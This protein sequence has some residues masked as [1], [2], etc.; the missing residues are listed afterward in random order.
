[1]PIDIEEFDKAR[2]KES[3][4][5]EFLYNNR[6]KAYTME[7]LYK[8]TALGALGINIETDLG[9]LA[10]SGYIDIQILKDDY[11]YAIASKGIKLFEKK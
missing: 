2:K 1:M 6:K 11:Y 7:E 10:S 5:L 8:L 3:I 4:L 9:S